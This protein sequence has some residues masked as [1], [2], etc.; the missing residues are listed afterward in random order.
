MGRIPDPSEFSCFH[1]L[2]QL[3][4]SSQ[5]ADRINLPIWVAA[6]LHQQTPLL[7]QPALQYLALSK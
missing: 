3:S 7:F 6:F 4:H 2:N 1:H 5:A